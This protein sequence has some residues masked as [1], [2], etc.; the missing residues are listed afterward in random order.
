MFADLFTG[1]REREQRL[2][3]VRL[4]SC[5]ARKDDVLDNRIELEDRKVAKNAAAV[6]LVVPAEHRFVAVTRVAAASL[7]VELDFD[8]DQIE[9]LRIGVNELVSLLVERSSA[10]ATLELVYTIQADALE[11]SGRLQ[12]EISVR[13]QE[14]D[15]LALQILDVVV[16][17]YLCDAASFWLTKHRWADHA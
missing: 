13:E 2:Y 7:A 15:E 10:G 12:G 8:V 1:E 6:V 16:D 17:S 3:A 5:P 14:I 11:V 4:L 9:E